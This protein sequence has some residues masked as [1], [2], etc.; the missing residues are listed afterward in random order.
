MRDDYYNDSLANAALPQRPNPADSKDLT[1]YLGLRARLSQTWI[2]RWTVLILLV[3]IRLLFAIGSTNQLIEGARSDALSACIEVEKVASSVVSLPHYMAQGINSLTVTGINKAVDGVHDMLDYTVT[4]VETIVEWYIGMVTDTYLCLATFAVGGSLDAAV[5]ILDDASGYLKTSL[6][7]ISGDLSGAA[8]KLETEINSLVSGINIVTGSGAP[9][10]DFS[11]EI[12]ALNNLQL[13]ANLTTELQTLKGSI[14]TFAQVKNITDTLISIPFEEVRTLMNQAWGN[15][16]FN[17]S[18]L[19]VP[20]KDTVSICTGNSNNDINIFFNDLRDVSHKM[21]NVFLGVLITAAILACIPAALLELRRWAKLQLRSHIVRRFAFDPLDALYL[22]ARPYT[23]DAG[24]WVAGRFSNSKTQVLMRWFVAYCTTLPALLLLAI[25]L[26]GFIS[27]LFQYV[28][29]KAIEKEAPALAAE[30]AG[31][32]DDV[33]NKV[34]NASTAWASD[35]N[36]VLSKATDEINNNLLGWVNITTTAVNNTL[37]KFVDETVGTLNE[38]FFGTPFNNAIQEVYNCLIGLKVQGIQNGL[39]W[40]SQHAQ[41]NFPTV[42]NNSMTIGDLVGK[43]TDLGQF[44]S[45]PTNVTQNDVGSA[46]TEVGEKMAEVIRQEAL[47]ALGVFICYLLVVLSGL[48]WTVYKLAGS[49]MVRQTGEVE[50][51]TY[52]ATADSKDPPPPPPPIP[53]ANEALKSR[54][55]SSP[56]EPAP[57]YNKTWTDVDVNS[58]APYTLNPHPIPKPTATEDPFGDEKSLLPKQPSRSSFWKTN[59]PF[60]TRSHGNEHNEK[61]G[62]I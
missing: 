24:R 47:V 48:A 28:L 42:P 30:I 29:L 34:N 55:S 6:N 56:T 16:S 37:N 13:P 35:T 21:R 40:V 9:K 31:A 59:N 44:L 14:P 33:V 43:D 60:Q 39:T 49:D 8:S 61:N 58:S 15:Y 12:T 50:I 32:I 41:V 54:F 26:A 3:L 22:S 57:A 5:G 18:L 4:G 11:S 46:V 51:F 2:N 19:P 62:F 27:C 17:S 52:A 20:A 1:P 45:N 10:V 36:G 23:S 38:T 53:A 25:A 7:G